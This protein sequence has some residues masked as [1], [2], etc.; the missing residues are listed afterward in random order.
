M[1]EA[2]EKMVFGVEEQNKLVVETRAALDDAINERKPV[3]V[4]LRRYVRYALAALGSNKVHTAATIGIDRR[5]IQRWEREGWE[6]E[7][8]RTV[9]RRRGGPARTAA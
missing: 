1:S 8:E 5:T 9:L 2:Q 6:R 3:A 4:I 7:G